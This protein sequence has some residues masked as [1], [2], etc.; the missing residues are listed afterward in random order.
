M[1]KLEY[2]AKWRGKTI[3]KIDQWIPSSQIC[4]NCGV[5]DGKKELGIRKWE[6]S[7]CI[8]IHDRDIN[9]AVNIKNYGLSQI[10]QSN[11]IVKIR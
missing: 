2:K 1:R 4:S 8:S 3:L 9:A 10:D 11:K 7:E 6:C 5:S